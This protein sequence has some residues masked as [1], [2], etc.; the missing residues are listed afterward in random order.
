MT[1]GSVET[2]PA[3]QV[4]EAGPPEATTLPPPPPNP[5]DT[6]P[7]RPTTRAGRRARAAAT[8]AAKASTPKAPKAAKPPPRR[9]PLEDRLAS[10]LATVGTA[11]VVAGAGTGS[12]AVQADG[13]LVVA[14]APNVAHALDQLARDNPAVAAA[15][16][17]MLTAGAW[18]GVIVACTPIAL[19]VAANH[20][21]LPQAVL[22]M[23][24]AA[25]D[26]AAG[27]DAPPA[28]GQS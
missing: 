5:E 28:D 3:A 19:G 27:P 22:D 15:L 20:G 25:P 13:M 8:K 1:T 2:P 4:P 21:L 14:H 11:I 12:Q 18:S 16:E 9:A 24:T 10:S 26:Q 6:K 23:L 7:K 17:R